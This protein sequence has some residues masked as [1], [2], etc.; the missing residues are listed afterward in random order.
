MFRHEL[1]A[2]P[3]VCLWEICLKTFFH[4]WNP[5]NFVQLVVQKWQCTFKSK[6]SLPA[7]IF[8]FSCVECKHHSTASYLSVLNLVIPEWL[9]EMPCV[10]LKVLLRGTGGACLVASDAY[11]PPR[12]PS[13]VCCCDLIYINISFAIKGAY[14]L[15][16]KWAKRGPYSDIHSLSWTSSIVCV[17][18]CCFCHAPTWPLLI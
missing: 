9:N 15:M 12:Q 5:V 6:T 14:W 17:R 4:F 10:S 7:P 13:F 2:L 16:L 8:L 3:F 18:L 11:F 1:L